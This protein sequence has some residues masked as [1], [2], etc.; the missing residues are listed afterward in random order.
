MKLIP[1]PETAEGL[2]KMNPDISCLEE[3]ARDGVSR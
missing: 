3:G 2:E 1:D